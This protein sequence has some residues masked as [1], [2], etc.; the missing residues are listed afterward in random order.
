[1]AQATAE[2]TAYVSYLIEGQGAAPPIDCGEIDLTHYVPVGTV[3]WDELTPW[4]W[5]DAA[6]D[7]LRDEFPGKRYYVANVYSVHYCP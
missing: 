5:Y 7:W 3:S 2:F 1:M 6:T 4:D